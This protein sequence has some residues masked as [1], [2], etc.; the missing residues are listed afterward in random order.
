M[1][2]NPTF[3]LPRWWWL[4]E[5]RVRPGRRRQREYNAPLLRVLTA[6]SRFV[7]Y[8]VLLGL[9]FGPPLLADFSDPGFPPG[10]SGE[11]RGETLTG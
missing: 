6:H 5:G 11:G 1:V 4:E 8:A 2:P 10:I 7:A 9:G 3:R